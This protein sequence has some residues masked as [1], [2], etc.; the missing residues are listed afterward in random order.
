[1]RNSIRFAIPIRPL[2]G[3]VVLSWL[4]VPSVEVNFCFKLCYASLDPLACNPLAANVNSADLAG[5][6]YVL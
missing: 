4:I 2:R 3:F 6:R 1:M 5:V